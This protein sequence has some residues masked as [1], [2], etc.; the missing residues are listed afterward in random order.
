MNTARTMP[1]PTPKATPGLLRLIRTVASGMLGIR[2][3]K[4]HEQD[5]PSLSPVQLIVIALAFMCIFVVTVVS[6]ATVVVSK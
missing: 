3:S 2:G 4:S 1:T 6:V 5:A